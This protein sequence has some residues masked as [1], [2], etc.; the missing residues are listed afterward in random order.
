MVAYDIIIRLVEFAT[1]EAG[2]A[3]KT[4]RFSIPTNGV[5]LTQ[6]R[7]EQ[8][9]RF[10]VA[11][12]ISIDGDEA[13]HNLMRRDK[14]GTGSYLR[15]R[16]NIPYII[17]NLSDIAAR[18]TV[19][20]QTVGRIAHSVDHLINLQF[21]K[22]AIGLN[23]D[24]SW[25]TNALRKL[26]RGL[27]KVANRY[28]ALMMEQ[29]PININF[30]DNSVKHLISGIRPEAPCGAGKGFVNIGINGD[31]YPCHHF[32][33]L[34]NFKGAH[35]LGNIDTGINEKARLPFIRYTAEK[36]LGCHTPC[37]TCK[38]QP[39]CA[40]GCFAKAYEATGLFQMSNPLEQQF[41]LIIFDVVQDLFEVLSKHR[42]PLFRQWEQELEEAKST[43]ADVV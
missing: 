43:V 10:P 42:P 28:L 41:I 9:S 20:P 32:T 14:H 3:G 27:R 6:E 38:A 8:L 5:L 1:H 13:T 16:Q 25:G 12:S 30:F 33:C 40:G 21:H 22:I 37:H 4:I 29:K 18:M 7:V 19:N 24:V 31:V 11:V 39:I 35:R 34:E 2:L 23:S 17:R 36:S 26:D 15:L